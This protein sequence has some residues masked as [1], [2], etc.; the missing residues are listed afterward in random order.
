MDTGK[1]IKMVRE[2]SSMG[3]RKTVQKDTEGKFKECRKIQRNAR[4]RIKGVQ[5][6]AKELRENQSKDQRREFQ[7]DVLG[8]IKEIQK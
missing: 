3:Y 5:K 4:G 1:R 7:K 6:E 8:I 2:K